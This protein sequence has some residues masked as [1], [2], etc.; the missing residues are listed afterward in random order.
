MK[1][2]RRFSVK[3]KSP[4]EGVPFSKRHSEIRNPNGSLVFDGVSTH[5]TLRSI[6]GIGEWT[7]QYVA[8]RALN[9]PDAFPSGDLVLRRMAGDLSTRALDARSLAWSPWRAYAVMLLWQSATELSSPPRRQSNARLTAA[10]DSR[11]REL[12]GASA[13]R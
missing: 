6:P 3:G 9:E 4:Y 12:V 8:M 7:A 2:T 10:P 1:V 11:R 5:E 13:A